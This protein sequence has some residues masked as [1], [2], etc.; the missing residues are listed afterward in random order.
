MLHISPAIMAVV[1][2]EH[3][4][5]SSDLGSVS[6]LIHHFYLSVIDGINVHLSTDDLALICSLPYCQKMCSD[7]LGCLICEQQKVYIYPG[8]HLQYDGF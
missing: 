8:E 1:K 4:R 5:C 7:M 6:T 2:T 3:V